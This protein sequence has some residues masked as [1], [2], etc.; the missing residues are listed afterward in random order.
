MRLFWT[1]FGRLRAINTVENVVL[2]GF[3]EELALFRRRCVSGVAA[4]RLGIPVRPLVASLRWA[5]SP[6]LPFVLFVKFLLLSL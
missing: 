5:F 4:E 3:I 6:T 1:I 2:S